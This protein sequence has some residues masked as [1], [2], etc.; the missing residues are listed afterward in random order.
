MVLRFWIAKLQMI[1]FPKDTLSEHFAKNRIRPLND[2][3]YSMSNEQFQQLHQNFQH[4]IQLFDLFTTKFS[5]FVCYFIFLI[6]FFLG[7]I[8][9]SLIIRSL[10]L[11]E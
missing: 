3:E 11:V 6:L 2:F 7:L 5:S 4:P 1:A 10:T 9:S 8:A